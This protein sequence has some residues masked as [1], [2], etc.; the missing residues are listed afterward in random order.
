M[1]LGLAE[2]SPVR[3]TATGMATTTYLD[4]G[5]GRI[6]GNTDNLGVSVGYE[7]EG[8]LVIQATARA[9]IEIEHSIMGVIQHVNTSSKVLGMLVFLNP[10]GWNFN[11]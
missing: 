7:E 6:N 3:V 5:C 1:Q 9:S 10:A 4:K 2:F 8:R 11:C